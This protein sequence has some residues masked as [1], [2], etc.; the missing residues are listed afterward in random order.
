MA[1][2]RTRFR[3]EVRVR[4]DFKCGSEVDGLGHGTLGTPGERESVF[5]VVREKVLLPK[6][7]I[8]ASKC[9]GQ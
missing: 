3:F 7:S 6:P 9:Y 8:A 4:L 5:V 2:L 1:W